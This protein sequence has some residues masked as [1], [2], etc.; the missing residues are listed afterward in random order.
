VAEYSLTHKRIG[1]YV[2]L[3]LTLI[4]LVIT[5][6]KIYGVKNNW[7]LFRKTAWAFY[8]VLIMAT[9]VNWSRLITHYNLSRLSNFK[10]L[11]IAYL[12]HLPQTNTAQL[13][14]LLQ[15]APQRLTETQK[16]A[17]AQKKTVFLERYNRHQWQSWNYD[18]YRIAKELE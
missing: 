7:F 4:G 8:V 13:N 9:A 16:A 10:E 14:E 2:Y 11:D 6:I 18:D 15:N 3:L 1:V 12:I 5:F 17:I